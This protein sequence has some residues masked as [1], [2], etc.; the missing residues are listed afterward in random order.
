MGQCNNCGGARQ[1]RYL[2]NGL[3]A[4]CIKKTG[5]V[6]KSAINVPLDISQM[7]DFSDDQQVDPDD[8]ISMVGNK[9]LAQKS[10]DFKEIEYEA[11][12]IDHDNLQE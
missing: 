4:T 7:I 10:L 11:G 9:R 8:S 1:V 2:S 5:C 6:S 12:A 3:C